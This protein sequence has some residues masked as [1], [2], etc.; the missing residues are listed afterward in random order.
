MDNKKQ[1]THRSHYYFLLSLFALFL[2]LIPSAS[3]AVDEAPLTSQPLLF[4][5]FILIAGLTLFCLLIGLGA[6]IPFFSILGFFL[7]FVIGFGIQGGNLYLPTGETYYAYGN[8]FTYTNGTNTAY[9]DSGVV[10]DNITGQAILFHEGKQYSAWNTGN[11]H[12]I[13]WFFMMIGLFA[14]LFNVFYVFGGRD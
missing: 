6:D 7:V 4:P 2:F 12:E 1:S 10:P 9:W 11:Y 14:T 5:V 13:G 8:N 3:S